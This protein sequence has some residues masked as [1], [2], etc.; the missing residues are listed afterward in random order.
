[1]EI[2]GAFYCK[3][4]SSFSVKVLCKMFLLIGG[5]LFCCP[6]HLLWIHALFIQKSSFCVLN[7]PKC[8]GYCPAVETDPSFVT[9][10]FV[11]RCVGS[12]P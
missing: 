4:N 10:K 7:L 9:R 1:M 2:T 3:K 11:T 6:P 12:A 8:I 5:Q